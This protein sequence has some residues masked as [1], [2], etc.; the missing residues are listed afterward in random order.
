MTYCKFEGNDMIR[1][2]T[3]LVIYLGL[4]FA[5]VAADQGRPPV[6]GFAGYEYGSGITGIANDMKSEGYALIDS[7]DGSLWYSSTFLGIDCELGYIFSGNRLV[8]GSFILKSVT[9]RDFAEVSKH[10]NQTY[11]VT[12]SIEIKEGGV[13][14]ATIDAP[15]SAITH[16]LDLNQNTHEVTYIREE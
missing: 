5:A 16:V 3:L 10:L 11:E 7:T 15:D 9:E 8:G 4:A 6:T 12:S 13:V 2:L 1:K 14:V